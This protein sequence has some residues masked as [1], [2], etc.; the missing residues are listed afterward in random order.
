MNPSFTHLGNNIN[1]CISPSYTNTLT[2]NTLIRPILDNNHVISN[3]QFNSVGSNTDNNISNAFINANPIGMANSVMGFNGQ[4]NSI[5]KKVDK[6]HKMVF[7]NESI[8]S[9]NNANAISNYFIEDKNK[10]KFTQP[11]AESI[12]PAFTSSNE[13]KPKQPSSTESKI[14][15]A[16]S[17]M[18]KLQ[19]SNN[20]DN[21]I[22][23]KTIFGNNINTTAKHPFM[24]SSSPDEKEPNNE[25]QGNDT[26]NKVENNINDGSFIV[27]TKDETYAK[28][29][30]SMVINCIP[31]SNSKV[32]SKPNSVTPDN[33]VKSASSEEKNDK[34]TCS[35]L[36]G[37][38][39]SDEL[40]TK[41][42]KIDNSIRKLI[43]IVEGNRVIILMHDKMIRNMNNKLDTLIESDN[44]NIQALTQIK[45]ALATAEVR[46]DN[47]QY[48]LNK[49][50]AVLSQNKFAIIS[51]QP[52]NNNSGS[53]PPDKKFEKRKNNIV[54]DTNSNPNSNLS[55]N[56]NVWNRDNNKKE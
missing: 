34:Y 51:N 23:P 9:I 11:F 16:P 3:P 18:Q 20:D 39:L 37:V 24:K 28:R 29:P 26:E 12:Q 21:N 14:E 47:H 25:I 4:I 45:G 54:A 46:I 49:V 2:S 6:S 30:V 22:V 32:I 38:H 40:I 48:V 56:S 10:P 55:N 1:K 33:N 15:E 43:D 8:H 42:D 44:A 13:G 5:E 7:D 19:Q 52:I 31:K 53:N 36:N 35:I 17:F 27:D 41:L 50:L